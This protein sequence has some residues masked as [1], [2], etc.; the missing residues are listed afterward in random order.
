MRGPEA[1]AAEWKEVGD[2]LWE[3][4]DSEGE[5][6]TSA[7]E[8]G[9]VWQ[10]VHRTLQVV[11]VEKKAAA[12]AAAAIEALE[13][14]EQTN[15][16]NPSLPSQKSARVRKLFGICNRPI[17]GLSAPISPT[18]QDIL[19][20]VTQ[21]EDSSPRP[22]R[23]SESEPEIAQPPNSVGVETGGDSGGA[24]GGDG[25]SQVTRHGGG[26]Q[27]GVRGGDQGDMAAQAEQIQHQCTRAHS[28]PEQNTPVTGAW[29]HAVMLNSRFP[30]RE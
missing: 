7:R 18:P 22:L 29:R 3:S 4:T 19:D 9:V 14:A 2:L 23:Q 27:G 10:K 11:T 8:L 26:T 30:P 20:Q 15:P 12:A 13:G 16:E 28:D 5:N 25:Q 17:R 21:A 1:C 24:E 6:R